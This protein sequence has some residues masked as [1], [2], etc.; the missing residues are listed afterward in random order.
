[1]KLVCRCLLTLTSF[2]KPEYADHWHK[3]GRKLKGVADPPFEPLQAAG[4]VPILDTDTEEF[5][6]LAHHYRLD[7]DT[8]EN[9]CQWNREVG[10][11][12]NVRQ[13]PRLIM[14]VADLCGRHDDARVWSFL[15]MLIVEFA[16]SADHKAFNEGIFSR[17]IESAD[18]LPTP[19]NL[20]PLGE[21]PD[22]STP[23]SGPAQ[24]S[25]PNVCDTLLPIA[26][27]R[28]NDHLLDSS[29]DLVEQLLDGTPSGSPPSPYSGSATPQT[30]RFKAFLPPDTKRI[31][32]ART[33]ISTTVPH[34]T[35]N[36]T[37]KASGQIIQR[38]SS[39]SSDEQDRKPNKNKL[40]NSMIMTNTA[41]ALYEWPDP[42]GIAPGLST[43]SSSRASSNSSPLPWKLEG[44]AAAA[45][46]AS[47]LVNQVP[48]I[49]TPSQGGAG[50][51]GAAADNASAT[52]GRAQ[53]MPRGSG[54]SGKRDSLTQSITAP[55]K[56]REG[57]LD[58]DRWEKYRE[59][60]CRPLLD[61]WRSYADDVSSRVVYWD[62]AQLR[63]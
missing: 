32:E 26:L 29:G 27:H 16:P 50:T 3:V 37:S 20:S 45:S 2:S 11:S 39:G 7:G 42:Y 24:S 59:R 8:P 1:V 19:P 61:W 48:L 13:I 41:K 56:G 57:A 36:H 43:G 62:G 4:S 52:G 34:D 5:V 46:R 17:P 22:M 31:S 38:G 47:P 55:V 6:Y 21:S 53:V 33:S 23:A 58:G 30:G 54:G 12:T 49:S 40:S 44:R 63:S 15:R 28:G 51:T 9:L 25:L 10:S 35:R 18:R 60:R 14:Q